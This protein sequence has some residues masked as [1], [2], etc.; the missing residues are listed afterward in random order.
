MMI[1]SAMTR[2]E[3]V[4]H[5]KESRGE[6]LRGEGRARKFAKAQVASYATG[7][8]NDVSPA[9]SVLPWL[10]GTLLYPPSRQLRVACKC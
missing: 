9:D 2:Y 1:G 4:R 10:P 8:A 7:P 6:L 3:A 5:E